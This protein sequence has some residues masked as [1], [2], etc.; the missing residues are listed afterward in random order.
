[1]DLAQLAIGSIMYSPSGN[2]ISFRMQVIDKSQKATTSESV[3]MLRPPSPLQEQHD[4]TAAK[5]A[6]LPPGTKPAATPTPV[7]TPDPSEQPVAEQPT[8]PAAEPL[9][10][11]RAA[12]LSQRLRPAAPTDMADAPTLGTGDRPATS[13]IPGVSMNALVPALPTPPAATP[14][15]SSPAEARPRSGGN[16]QQRPCC[17]RG[18]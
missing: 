14:A 5:A 1:M 10:Q 6:G 15:A 13:A 9:K 12:S 4:A 2:D 18:S 17:G 8:K 7:G 16:I 3:R 11:F